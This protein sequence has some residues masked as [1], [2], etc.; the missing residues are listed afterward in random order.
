MGGDNFHKN[1]DSNTINLGRRT[2]TTT[3]TCKT[4]PV[5]RSF[6]CFFVTRKSAFFSLPPVG[7]TLRKSK[8][9]KNQRNCNHQPFGASLPLLNAAASLRGTGV[10][11]FVSVYVCVCVRKAAA[12]ATKS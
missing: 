10:G 8:V 1:F 6:L 4:K 3:P 11:L 7:F 2:P 9:K 5:S 12:F